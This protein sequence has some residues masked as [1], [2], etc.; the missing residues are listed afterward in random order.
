MY[1]YI[2]ADQ[3]QR[4]NQTTVGEEQIQEDKGTNQMIHQS[5]KATSMNIK[6]K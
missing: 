6:K 4:Y 5:K 2:N 1:I 3:N